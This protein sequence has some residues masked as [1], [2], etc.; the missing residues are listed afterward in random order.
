MSE[1]AE[2][3]SS[4]GVIGADRVAVVTG[5][6]SGIG[7]AL[8]EGLVAEGSAVVVADLD[9]TEAQVVAERLRAGGGKGRGGR[10]RCR[11]SHV[12]RRPRRRDAPDVRA[13]G[14]RLQQRRRLHLQPVPGP[15]PRR[16]ALGARRRPLGRGQRDP[17]LPPDPAT[18]G[19]DRPHREH[20]LHGRD[21]GWRAIHRPVHGRQG[22]RHLA[23]GDA[24]DR[25][26]HDRLTHRRER[27]LP[28]LHG[29]QRDG[30]R[31]GPAG[32]ARRRAPHRRRTRACGWRSRRP[33]RDR[34]AFPP[35]RS[36][37]GPSTPCGPARSGSSAIRAS[38]PRS[39]SAST[40][41]SPPSRPP[42]A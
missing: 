26:G 25:A 17:Q 27:A 6:A 39:S 9:L 42:G 11:R 16:L 34:T 19:H 3:G 23:V 24:P 20:V 15:D 32:R 18:P 8:C 33:S 30:V 36:P 35:R 13:G 7:L 14:P 22:G 29:Q 4:T 38:G 5:G 37:P 12:G 28:R 10:R 40:R 1:P 21:H 31:A 41:C 2:V